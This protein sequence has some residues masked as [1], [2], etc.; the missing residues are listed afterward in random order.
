M[1]PGRERERRSLWVLPPENIFYPRPFSIRKGPDWVQRLALYT[2]KS[3]VN[4]RAKMKE[5]RQNY[6]KIRVQDD[7]ITEYTN[8]ESPLTF[9]N[10]L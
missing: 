5:S 4:E 6:R 1:A 8:A 2:R 3:Y 9:R 7:N 10:L